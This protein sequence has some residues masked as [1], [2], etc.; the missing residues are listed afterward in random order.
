MPKWN[1]CRLTL[2]TMPYTLPRLLLSRVR[3]RAGRSRPSPPYYFFPANSFIA[4][5]S[6]LVN[7]SGFSSLGVAADGVAGDNWVSPTD[8]I[9][10]IFG[11]ANGGGSVDAIDF[12]AF[13]G[14]FGTNNA[15][16]D[17]DNGGAV[18]ALDFS[19]FLRRFGT[20]I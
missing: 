5:C 9:F 20:G 1:S 8:S 2:E 4:S 13:L 6:F 3:Q 10:R 12:G 16:F 19:Q 7:S 11:D 14:A 15:I 17:F 18:D